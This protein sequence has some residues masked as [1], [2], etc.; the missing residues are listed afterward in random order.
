VE[1][2]TEEV[3]ALKSSWLSK[4]PEVGEYQRKISDSIPPGDTRT[5]ALTRTGFLR[6]KCRYTQACN[7]QFQGLAASG[8]KEALYRVVTSGKPIYPIAFLHDEILAEVPIESANEQANLLTKIMV[9]TMQKLCVDVPIT[10][11]PALMHRWYKNA[12][13]V[14]DSSGKLQPWEPKT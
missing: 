12:E 4:Y 14:R 9:D 2:T 7:F 10:A 5:F 3:K 11:S 8:A 1:L 13:T 6:G